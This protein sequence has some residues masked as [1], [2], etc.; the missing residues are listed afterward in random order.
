[1]MVVTTRAKEKLKKIL[2]DKKKE[3]SSFIRLIFSAEGGARL[4][5]VFDRA[6]KGDKAVTDRGGVRVLL[7]GSDIAAKLGDAVLDCRETPEGIEF[8][9]SD[10][11][12][13]YR[14]LASPARG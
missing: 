5:F 6:G 13:E 11:H 8:F 12:G 7:V 10:F 9:I 4:A 3:P 14:W 1:M 2:E